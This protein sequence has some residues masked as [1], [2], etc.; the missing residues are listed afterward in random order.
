MTT[1]QT[2]ELAA[3]AALIIGAVVLYRRRGA[4][5][6]TRTGSQSAV[7]LL[8]VGAIMAIHALGLMEYRP[9]QAEIDHSAEEA[10]R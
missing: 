2:I 5:G 10:A 1:T 3:A 4:E 9:S 6:E 8:I 7:I